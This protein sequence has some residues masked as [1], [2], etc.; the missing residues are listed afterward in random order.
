MAPAAHTLAVR[1]R[2]RPGLVAQG[3][4]PLVFPGPFLA[5]TRALPGHRRHRPAGVAPLF[6]FRRPHPRDRTPA[7]GPTAAE[8]DPPPQPA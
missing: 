4:S 7:H 2:H 8:R 6:P 5:G 3:A 1:R